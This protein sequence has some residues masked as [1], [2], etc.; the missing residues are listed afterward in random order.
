MGALMRYADWSATPLGPAEAWSPAL[1]MMTNFLLANRFPQMLWWGPLFSSLY[2]DAYIPILGAKHPWALGRP[3][4]EIWK[5]IWD[6]LKPLIETP[7]HGG[8]ATWMEDI[9][10]ELNRSGFFE[11]THFTIA[12]SPV[13]D[14]SVPGGIGGVLATVHEITDKVIGERR[15]RALRELGARSAD[16]KSAEDA[17]SNIGKTLSSFSRDLP[18]LLLYLLD[19]KRQ[20]ASLACCLGVSADDRACPESIR[21]NSRDGQ[22]WPLLDA[23]ATGEIQIVEDLKARFD[24]LPKGPWAEPPDTAAVVPIRSGVQRQL[25][26]FMIA[27]L[28]SRIR[29]DRNYRDFLELLSTQIAA[30]IANASAYEQERKRAESLAELDRAKTLFF[31]NIGHELRTPL[32]LL[33]GPTESALSSKSGELLGAELEMMHR[34]ELRLLKLINTLLDFSRIEAG[35]VRAVFEP[36]ELCGLTTDIASEFRSAMEKAGLEFV[37]SCEPIEEPVYVDRQMWEKIVLN[38]L[39]NA[40]KFTFEGGVEL[41]LARAGEFV[42]LI[43]RDTGV[44]IPPDQLSRIFERFHRVENVRA[45]TA[46]GTGIGLALVHE[47]VRLHGG[48]VHVESRLGHGATFRVS[49]PLG[50]AHLPPGQLGN[51]SSA[52]DRAIGAAPYVQEALRWLPGATESEETLVDDLA[53]EPREFDRSR[54]EKARQALPRV[55]LADD[56]RDMREYL[57]RLLD[58]R[59]RVTAVENGDLALASALADPP[60]LVLTDVMMPGLD[61]FG[62]LRKL[63]AHPSTSGVPVIMLSARAGEEAE[64]EGLEAGAD[65][66]LIKPF[67]ARELLARVGTHISMYRLRTE[68]MRTEHQL[69][70]KAEET[71]RQYRDILESISEAFLFI[72]RNWRV[73]YANG[74]WAARG[75]V[76]WPQD[77]GRVIWQISPELADTTFGRAYQEA[78]EHSRVVSVEDYYAPLDRWFHVNVYPC[79]DGISIFAQDVTERRIRQERLLLTEKL[80]AT[81]RLA[82]TIAHEINNPLESVLNLI[83]LARTAPNQ[84]QQVQ[85]LLTIAE[86]E[87]TRISHIARHTLGFYRETSVPSQVNLPALLE[88]VLTV[89]ESRLHAASIQ[90][91][92]DFAAVPPVKALRGEMH[93]VFSNLISNALDAM[94]DG[95]T[96][97]IVLRKAE[98][99]GR[100][101]IRVLIDDNGVGIPGE[102]LPR[103]FEPFF[104]T[105]KSA[106]TGLGLWVVK[107]FVQSW[108]GSIEVASSIEPQSH[109]TRFDLF[110]P[111]LALSKTPSET[112]A[113]QHAG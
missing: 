52:R 106:G 6:V 112:G 77:L 82:A 78:M 29:F 99:S 105:K 108:G 19:E 66:Y 24:G 9:S 38:L 33:L 31:S 21:L 40:F 2:N 20:T 101:G 46:E 63:R 69:R 54:A 39:S 98:Q 75:K 42:E 60:D 71:E 109:G 104:T 13:P 34:S 81:G 37:I 59:Y 56:N 45:R 55:L 84:A 50:S 103:L 87:V 94:R 62:L 23:K 74:H 96:L 18:F 79:S 68:M 5:E 91:H 86:K 93:Q 73:R 30:M 15:I 14:E 8:P 100:E 16:P 26:G 53:G 67:T 51:G 58:R 49:I 110:V 36:V 41:Q 12:Y 4:C 70:M 65:D 107:Q 57:E 44:G 83:Y 10:L 102:I 27:G 89:Y 76:N 95:G 64:S 92:R 32:T 47:L 1:R 80:A 97:T 22:A 17:C 28:S 25:A 48:Q 3:V 11:E 7:F 85:Q 90:V 43:V 35:S 72:D 111:L 88:E 113:A 61:G